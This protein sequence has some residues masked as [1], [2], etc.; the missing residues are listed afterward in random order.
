MIHAVRI[1][2]SG[3][4]RSAGTAWTGYSCVGRYG[5]GGFDFGGPELFA[6]EGGAASAASPSRH[7]SPGSVRDVDPGGVE[8]KTQLTTT[9]QTQMFRQTASFLGLWAIRAPGTPTLGENTKEGA[10]GCSYRTCT[11]SACRPFGPFTTS[12][13]TAWPS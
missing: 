5:A 2:I 12:N 8:R 10:S 7:R 9:L 13:C 1:P 11:L 4:P 3:S 6:A